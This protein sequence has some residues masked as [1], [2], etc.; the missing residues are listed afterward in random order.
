MNSYDYKYADAIIS[1]GNII[2]TLIVI[3]FLKYKLC[4]LDNLTMYI[5]IYT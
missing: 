2:I 1:I 4:I 5:N 3:A